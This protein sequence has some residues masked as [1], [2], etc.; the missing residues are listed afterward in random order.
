MGDAGPANLVCNII[1]ACGS[2]YAIEDS[3]NGW[4]WR[5]WRWVHLGYGSMLI[6]SG[7]GIWN[8]K[9]QFLM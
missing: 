7:L 4:A 3:R 5:D 8:C 9:W 2:V 6:N 1:L